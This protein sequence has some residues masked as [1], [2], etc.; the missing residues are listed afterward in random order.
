MKPLGVGLV[1]AG[2]V[3]R[4]IHVPT[5]ARLDGRFRV[6]H[7]MDANARVADDLARVLSARCS[8]SLESL[9]ADD[10]VDVVA[11]CSPDRLHAQQVIA[12]CA[13]GKRA[14]LCEK[15][16]AGTRDEALAMAH[17]A[18]ASSTHLVV[19]AMHVYDPAWLAVTT[20]CYALRR[21]ATVIRSSIVLPF[22]D[23]YENWSSEPLSRPQSNAP[24]LVTAKQRAARLRMRILAL[25]IHDLPLV[26]S[27]LSDGDDVGVVATRLLEPMGYY[28]GLRCGER[29]VELVGSFR[30]HW[31]PRWEFDVI[32]PSSSLHMEFP[33][34]YVHAGSA[35]ATL[36]EN[37]QRR[38]FGHSP[39]DGY[40]NEWLHIHRLLRAG[41]P[42]TADD[43]ATIVADL[44]FAVR[45]ADLSSH[46]MAVA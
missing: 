14:V 17:A 3:A 15:P 31:R 22:N 8:N 39:R 13:A 34:S 7:V 21:D 29:L 45:I 6:T 37:S 30:D 36:V 12:A 40:E 35:T 33:P 42:P 23:R 5:L 9:L 25:S 4:G 26:R 2:S 10:S 16:L 18:H 20:E 1:G 19:G 27:F 41:A 32:A 28:V 38:E 43:L 46:A 44:C 24:S 11:V